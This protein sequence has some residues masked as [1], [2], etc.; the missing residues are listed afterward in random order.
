LP[1]NRLSVEGQ[2]LALPAIESFF[3]GDDDIAK[4]QPKMHP[5]T[6]GDVTHLYQRRA[7]CCRYYL[8]PAGSL[9]EE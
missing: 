7:S 3:S 1:H 2:A 8:L 9:C 4:M 6:L 5:V